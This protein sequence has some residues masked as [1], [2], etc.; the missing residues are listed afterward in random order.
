MSVRQRD[1]R[2]PYVCRYCGRRS[3]VPSLRAMHE[4]RCPQRPEESE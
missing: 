4:A 3:V 2:S 1:D